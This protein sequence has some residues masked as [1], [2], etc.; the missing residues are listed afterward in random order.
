MH[1]AGTHSDSVCGRRRNYR[2]HQSEL[3]TIYSQNSGT[4]TLANLEIGQEGYRA[5]AP[6][7]RCLQK[8]SDTFPGQIYHINAVSAGASLLHTKVEGAYSAPS[9]SRARS[10]GA[11]HQKE[12]ERAGKRGR[13]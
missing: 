9:N 4:E 10:G 5:R 13:R 3:L 12:V 7:S 8:A 11:L 2:F 6:L 1:C